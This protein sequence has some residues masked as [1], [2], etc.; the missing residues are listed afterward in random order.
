MADAL[1]LEATV[2]RWFDRVPGY[3]NTAS[4]G[5]PPKR[6]IAVCRERLLE[7]QAG[8]GDPP[9]FDPDVSRS[10]TAFASIAGTVPELVGI[11]GQVSTVA[12]MT[13]ASLD[14]GAVVLCAEEEFTSVTFPFLADSRLETR[15][16]PLDRL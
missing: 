16:V 14:D 13:A 11:V 4:I 10:R 5:L 6:T 12:G 1:G 9:S 7:W 15:F 3:L 2:D 8:R